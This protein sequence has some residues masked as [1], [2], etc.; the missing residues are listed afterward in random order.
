MQ[1]IGSRNFIE[2]T[3]AVGAFENGSAITNN[4]DRRC[5]WTGNGIE[6]LIGGHTYFVPLTAQAEGQEEGYEEQFIF[7][8]VLF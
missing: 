1:Y 2:R 3:S 5:R 8:L 4:D 7:H 6:C